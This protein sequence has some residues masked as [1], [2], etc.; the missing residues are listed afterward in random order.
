MPDKYLIVS[1]KNPPGY[2]TGRTWSVAQED[3]IIQPVLTP[4]RSQHNSRLLL[5]I[6]SGAEVGILRKN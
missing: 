5:F 1:E 4:A 6:S 3:T 2:E